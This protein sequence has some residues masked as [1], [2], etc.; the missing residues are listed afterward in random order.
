LLLLEGVAH[1]QATISWGRRWGVLP[2]YLVPALNRDNLHVVVK[3]VV[4]RVCD[5]LCLHLCNVIF[6]GRF[7]RP[8]HL[9]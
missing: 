7:W 3:A 8:V 9:T 2:T 4:T 6:Y 1:T 5:L